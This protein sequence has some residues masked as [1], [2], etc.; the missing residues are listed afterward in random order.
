[1][2]ARLPLLKLRYLFGSLGKERKTYAFCGPKG[3]DSI[4]QANGLGLGPMTFPS[5][6]GARPWPM[7]I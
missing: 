1:M 6:K 2:R 4:A 3:R 7:I 5:P